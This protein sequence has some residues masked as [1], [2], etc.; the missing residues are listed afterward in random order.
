[1]S[2]LTYKVYGAISISVS[3]F[4]TVYIYGIICFNLFLLTASTYTMLNSS[5]VLRF[6]ER[7]RLKKQYALIVSCTI[8]TLFIA[9]F[10]IV[11]MLIFKNDLTP[12]L[13]LLKG[14]AHFL[15]IWLLSNLLAAV[16]GSSISLLVRNKFAYLLS[17]LVYGWFVWMSMH[18]PAKPIN[19]YLNIF[20]DSTY[21]LS[22]NISGP[23]FN[24]N[25]FLDKLFL[26]LV[27]FLLIFLVR[28]VVSSKRRAINCFILGGLIIS[29]GVLPIWSQANHQSVRIP[30]YQTVKSP[31]KIQKYTMN[32]ELTNKL[33]NKATMVINFPKDSKDI[34]LA[35][36][37][38][39]VVKNLKLDH[40]PV[41]FTHKNNVVTIPSSH[42]QGESVTLTMEYEGFV[43][44]V[45]DIGVNTYYVTK[46]AINLPGY[47][48]DWY[49]NIKGQGLSDFDVS[50]DAAAKKVYSN[51]SAVSSNNEKHLTGSS[52]SLNL[53]AGQY[54]QVQADQIQYI[55]PISDNIDGFKSSFQS[56]IDTI[57]EHAGLSKEDLFILKNKNYTRVIVGIWPFEINS[58]SVQVIGDTVLVNYN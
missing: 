15:I 49:P 25:Y 11:L 12:P 46:S 21:I 27:L 52:N 48:F 8:I 57:P 16:I 9:L 41:S 39:F 26:I 45:N 13:F 6:L 17:L 43:D 2:F 36:D 30:A 3:Y 29:V 20:D 10:P 14:M 38:I 22:N 7:D 35:L 55:I 19:R 24:R 42:K 53:F 47:F 23:L 32:L 4:T 1:M 18:S 56:S 51:I 40:Q 37:D 44:V 28:S 50:I 31:Y 5:T 54:Q 33:K 58:H 34:V